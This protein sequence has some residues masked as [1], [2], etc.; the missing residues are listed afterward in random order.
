[1]ATGLTCN[2][3]LLGVALDSI[4]CFLVYQLA[5]LV[6]SSSCFYSLVWLE[7]TKGPLP[8]VFKL[9]WDLP[10]T[11]PIYSGA[12]ICGCGCVYVCIY[13]SLCICQYV[14]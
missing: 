14:F 13:V 7:R 2:P 9:V 5:H 4:Q 3:L 11:R 8:L 10:T 1:M 6:T 12:D